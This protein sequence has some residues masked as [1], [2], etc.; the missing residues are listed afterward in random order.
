MNSW[1][2]TQ[3]DAFALIMMWSSEKSDSIASTLFYTRRTK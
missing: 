3:L 2:L 1:N